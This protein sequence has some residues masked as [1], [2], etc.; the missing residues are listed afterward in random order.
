[1]RAAITV[2]GAAG[3]L[4]LPAAPVALAGPP[5]VPRPNTGRGHYPCTRDAAGDRVPR[6]APVV[7]GPT[8]VGYLHKGKNW[9][10]CQQS[11]G[12]VH[13]AAGD[14]NTWYGWTEADNT[15]W[16]WASALEAQGGDDYGPFGG[17]TPNCNGAHGAPPSY[18]G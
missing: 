5:P 11:G 2:L 16:G 13:D 3:A 18:T 6:G 12:D 4:P 8:T 9:L 1:M 10:V 17:G 7:V 14:H 15:H